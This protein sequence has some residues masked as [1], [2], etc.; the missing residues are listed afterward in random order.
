[1]NLYSNLCG[2]MFHVEKVTIIL[3]IV[4]K[5]ETWIEWMNLLVVITFST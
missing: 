2:S 3:Y 4:I 5:S 1:M